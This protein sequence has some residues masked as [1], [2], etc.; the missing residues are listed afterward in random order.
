MF[1][2]LVV[3]FIAILIALMVV[4]INCNAMDLKLY[5]IVLAIII[6]YSFLKKLVR[7]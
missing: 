6:I 5:Y 4:I 7:F 2:Y 1:F 3:N